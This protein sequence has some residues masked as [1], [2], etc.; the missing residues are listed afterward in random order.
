MVRVMSI[1]GFVSMLN[2]S[3]AVQYIHL[4]S[5]TKEY[6]DVSLYS[7]CFVNSFDIVPLFQI[8]I[9][10]VFS[11]YNAFIMYLDMFSIG[12]SNEC[13]IALS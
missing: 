9:Y 10:F 3:P 7:P 12:L 13:R 1:S 5:H 11:R 4:V 6:R 2:C 8:I